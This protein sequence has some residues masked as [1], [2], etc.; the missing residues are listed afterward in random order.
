MLAR[1]FGVLPNKIIVNFFV[2]DL[3]NTQLASVN[4][5]DFIYLMHW[6]D[7]VA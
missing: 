3:Q 6:I 4:I 1:A 7:A 2:H 5:Q